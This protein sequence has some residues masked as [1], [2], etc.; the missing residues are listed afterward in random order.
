MVETC[1]HNQTPTY[2]DQLPLDGDYCIISSHL[3][4]KYSQEVTTVTC[5]QQ[6]P[7]DGDYCIISS[8]L[9]N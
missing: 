6:L 1:N 8:H 9:K 7:R 5:F 4:Q 3:A 2:K